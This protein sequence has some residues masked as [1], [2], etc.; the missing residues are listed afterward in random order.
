MIAA[1]A[2]TS[3][4]PNRQENLPV[5]KN[6]LVIIMSF[7]MGFIIMGVE[8]LCGKLMSPY[9]GA[10]VHVWGSII[11]TFM[12]AL[13]VGY[14]AGGYWSRTQPSLSRYGCLFG[15]ASICLLPAIAA[16]PPFMEWVMI[17]IEDPRT[18]SLVSTMSLFFLPTVFMGMAAPYAIRLLIETTENSGMTS[19]T[20]YF[21]STLGSAFGT[22]LTSFYF[23]LWLPLNTLLYTACAILFLT[24]LCAVSIDKFGGQAD[25]KA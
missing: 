25:A 15:A 13:S 22:I 3:A 21:V 16:A 1:S 18:G 12:L 14:L 4:G 7:F 6:Y 5:I 19:G 2:D 9:F 20:L 11:F 17:N 10:S 24:G 23:I 8:L